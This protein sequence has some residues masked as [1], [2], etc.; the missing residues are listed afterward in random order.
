[1]TPS[2]MTR[3]A[4][5]SSTSS[6]SSSF[7]ADDPAAVIGERQRP[8]LAALADDQQRFMAVLRAGP[9]EDLR[10]VAP[11]GLSAL[12]G[13]RGGLARALTAYRLNACA[14]AERSLAAVYLRLQACL[15]DEQPG[16]F[17]ALAWSCW[18]RAG[19]V[20]ADLAEWGE[21]L[22]DAL[23]ESEVTQGS[24]AWWTDLARVEWAWHVCEQQVTGSAFDMTSL[25]LL[26]C[27]EPDRLRLQ[28]ADGVQWVTVRE[29]TVSSVLHALALNEPAGPQGRAR[30][31]GQD[32]ELASQARDGDAV[33]ISHANANADAG[34]DADADADAST[35]IRAVLI[36]RD[37]WRALAWPLSGAEMRWMASLQ[38]GDRLGDALTQADADF[39]FSAW[40]TAALQHGWLAAVVRADARDES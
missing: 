20:E 15:A 35:D 11:Q 3:D 1:M 31:T 26:S 17:A 25:S 21:G 13:V 27:E 8:D 37:G 23:A 14:L 24:P 38:R 33:D 16:G 4:S 40:L 36:W 32:I 2:N 39:D 12:P 22:I 34:A 9:R 6:T 29:A 10:A 30:A 19:P 28:L 18:R 7:Q 5:T